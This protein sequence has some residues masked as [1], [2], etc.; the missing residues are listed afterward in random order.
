[1]KLFHPSYFF[2]YFFTSWNVLCSVTWHLSEVNLLFVGKSWCR[3]FS[4]L[5]KLSR[6]FSIISLVVPHYSA[7]SVTCISAR[8]KPKVFPTESSQEWWNTVD[9]TCC[10]DPHFIKKKKPKT[11]R[12]FF[13]HVD[14]CSKLLKRGCTRNFQSFWLL[15]LQKDEFFQH[16]D[17]LIWPLLSCCGPF[18][19]CHHAAIGRA[20]QQCTGIQGFPGWPYSNI[21][22]KVNSWSGDLSAALTSVLAL[23]RLLAASS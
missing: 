21:K 16:F 17:M 7:P 22:A 1:M 19:D 18:Q 4:P 15:V 23:S 3:G 12:K 10:L 2:M 20:A 9:F 13:W 14:R 5:E 6:F 8:Y 11:K